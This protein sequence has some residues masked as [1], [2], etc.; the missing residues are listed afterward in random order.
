MLVLLIVNT[1]Y[2]AVNLDFLVG[3]CT[4]NACISRMVRGS[5]IIIIINMILDVVLLI[6]IIFLASMG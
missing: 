5:I 6:I 1:N 4:K 2:I 3:T